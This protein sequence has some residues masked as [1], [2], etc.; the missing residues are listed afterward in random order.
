MV[1][2]RKSLSC[3]LL[4]RLALP[5]LVILVGMFGLTASARAADTDYK[6]WFAALDVAL[7]QPDSLDQHY[8]NNVVRTAGAPSS[9]TSERLVMDNDSHETWRLSVG[10][11]F[12][13]TIHGEMGALKVSYW[14]F[15]H[16]DDQTNKGLLGEVD[17]TIFGYGR[18]AFEYIRDP[19]NTTYPI[20]LDAS[21]H[22]KARTY[23]IDYVR[24]MVS[25]EKL[26]IK[27]LA[28]LRVASFEENQEL[29]AFDAAGPYTYVQTKH[30][31]SDAKGPRFGI[32][33]DFGFTK[34]FSLEG[35]MAVSF[36]Q[37]NTKGES[38][39]ADGRGNTD[40]L[41][42]KDDHIRGAIRDYDLKAVWSYGRLDYFLGYTTSEWDG[43]V[44]DPVPAS[45][46]SNGSGPR[47]RDTISFN[48]FHGGVIW[49]FGKAGP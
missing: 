49:R 16:G 12:G 41:E 1:K 17:E 22:V 10:Y 35:G 45:T 39:S 30:V 36:L 34:H 11:N 6:G 29:V 46:S 28:G 7:T 44:T 13:K 47:V 8:A 27:W 31:K 21:S 5:A 20:D 40:S 32:A 43:L 18:S 19:N 24:P 42:A 48:S 37:A 38:F 4:G 23:D 33:A 26:T 14:G 3:K 2:V 9:S 15:D 25:S